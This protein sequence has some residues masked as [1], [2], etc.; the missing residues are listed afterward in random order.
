MGDFKTTGSGLS[1][2]ATFQA[3]GQYQWMIRL[4]AEPDGEG[5]GK[6][7]D[8]IPYTGAWNQ[9]LNRCY[10]QARR[11]SYQVNGRNREVWG[12]IC[13]MDPQRQE[14]RSV[15]QFKTRLKEGAG[16]EVVA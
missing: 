14:W 13:R 6:L 9:V 12:E 15:F 16:P 7:D 8:S 5:R 2:P 10:Q 3:P 4:F 1:V 11:A